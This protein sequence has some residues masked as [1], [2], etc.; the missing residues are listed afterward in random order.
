MHFIMEIVSRIMIN[1]PRQVSELMIFVVLLQ[2]YG[3][4]KVALS[5]PGRMSDLKNNPPID[6][7]LDQYEGVYFNLGKRVY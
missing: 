7:V 3:V 1:K 5:T 4:S 6:P 2:I